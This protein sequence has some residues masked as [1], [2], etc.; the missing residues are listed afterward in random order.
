MLG[1]IVLVPSNPE[2]SYFQLMEAI[3][4]MVKDKDWGKGQEKMKAQMYGSMIMYMSSQAQNTLPYRL[5]NVDSN[6]KIFLGNEDFIKDCEG[7]LDFLFDQI[8]EIIS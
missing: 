6:D 3:M 2:T 5:P 7:L 4:T 8:L 1:F